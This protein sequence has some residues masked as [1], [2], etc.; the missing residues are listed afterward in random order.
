MSEFFTQASGS[1]T[2]TSQALVA[3]WGGSHPLAIPV[4][5]VTHQ[6][7]ADRTDTDTPPIF[8]TE[9]IEA[10]IMQAKTSK[11]REGLGRVIADPPAFAVY[12]IGVGA[13][14]R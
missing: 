12:A 5:V 3:G 6:P 11:R 10:A 14:A 4:F 8:A 9:G 13:R 7:P 1:L 2:A